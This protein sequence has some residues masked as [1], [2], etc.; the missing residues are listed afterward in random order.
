MLPLKS[1]IQLSL[2]M[3]NL[4]NIDGHFVSTG[5][6]IKPLGT[7]FLM[8]LSFLAHRQ[9]PNASLMSSSP[10]MLIQFH[11]QTKQGAFD[12]K[13]FANLYHTLSNLL[14]PLYLKSSSCTRDS[15]TLP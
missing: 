7:F 11:L 8:A 4:A 1:H 2:D 15:L 12:H 10:L 3:C 14:F 5:F 9:I 6:G 13:L